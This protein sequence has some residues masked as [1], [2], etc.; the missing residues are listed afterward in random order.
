MTESK[1]ERGVPVESTRGYGH[2]DVEKE[3]V[4]PAPYMMEKQGKEEVH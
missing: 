2:G 1:M 4:I 3:Y